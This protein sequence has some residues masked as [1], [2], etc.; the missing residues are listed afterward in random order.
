MSRIISGQLRI[1]VELVD[2]T[3][4]VNAAIDVVRPAA[5][6]K[7]V[8]LPEVRSFAGRTSSMGTPG[9]YSRWSGTS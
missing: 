5:E 8:E 7:G 3:Q 6:A 1:D 2:V 4:V 9:D